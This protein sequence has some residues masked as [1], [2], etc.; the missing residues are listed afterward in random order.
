V[1]LM[2]QAFIQIPPDKVSYVKKF[3]DEQQGWVYDDDAH[4]IWSGG[5]DKDLL[6]IKAIE[7]VGMLK[8]NGVNVERWE[9]V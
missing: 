7:V 6:R 1:D 9:I 8:M 5:P 2:C 3:W 4:C